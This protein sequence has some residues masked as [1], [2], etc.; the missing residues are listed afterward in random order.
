[1]RRTVPADAG[2]LRQPGRKF[3]VVVDPTISIAP[4]PTDA[5]NTMIISDSAQASTNFN[6]SWRLSVGTDSGGAVRSLL[7]FP[8]GAVPAGTQLDSADL[9][10]YYDQNFGS[11]GSNETIE[12]HQA[13]APWSASTATWANAGNNVG[14]LGNNQVVTDD[15]ATASTSASGAWPTPVTSSAVN[16]E[17]R[18]DQDTTSG[19]TFTWVPRLTESGSYQVEAH[20][21]A[22]STAASNA[23][24]TVYYNGGGPSYPRSHNSRA[25]P[26][27]DPTDH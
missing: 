20:Y 27:L 23:P 4:T 8:L 9:N 26:G 22:S 25:R 19:D 3:P 1:M 5:Q 10:L 6:S 12:A 17:Y 21:V 11:P 14:Q 24:Y 13:T 7:S 15:S 2:W 16:G 18:Y